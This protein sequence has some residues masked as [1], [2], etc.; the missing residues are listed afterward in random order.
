MGI[1]TIRKFGPC[2]KCAWLLATPLW[3]SHGLDEKERNIPDEHF[4]VTC[5]RCNYKWREEI[6]QVERSG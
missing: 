5:N 1:K 6:E 4:D 2:P 3:C